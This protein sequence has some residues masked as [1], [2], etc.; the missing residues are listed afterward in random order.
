M[1][2]KQ[3]VEMK[4]QNIDIEQATKFLL[5]N[6]WESASFMVALCP[7]FTS[8]VVLHLDLDAPDTENIKKFKEWLNEV[9]RQKTKKSPHDWGR[10]PDYHKAIKL[11][12]QGKSSNEIAN[13][14]FPEPDPFSDDESQPDLNQDAVMRKVY[15][16]L[17]MG[18]NLIDGGY[19]NIK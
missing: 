9:K 17:D 7:I 2:R 5:F 11:K 18:K 16:Y 13:E 8:E 15:R 1:T 4:I 3:I 6:K 19:K 14:M 10:L 12:K